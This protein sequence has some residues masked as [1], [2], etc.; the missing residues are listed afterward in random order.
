M[1]Q[2]LDRI[3]P[4]KIYLLDRTHTFFHSLLKKKVI[5]IT[6]M[7]MI[8]MMVSSAPED[9]ISIKPSG[10]LGVPGRAVCQVCGKE[11]SQK[12]DA[13]RQCWNEA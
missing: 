4:M 5:I 6:M 11:F 7:M 3:S 9:Y 2:S 13:K 1:I 8:M 10:R 12:S